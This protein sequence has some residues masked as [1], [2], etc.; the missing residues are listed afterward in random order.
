MK[1]LL[2]TLFVLLSFTAC[3][4]KEEQA[5]QEEARKIELAEFEAQKKA[6]KKAEEAQKV[7]EAEKAK[8]IEEAKLAKKALEDKIA[9]EQ[10]AKIKAQKE[11]EE[12]QKLNALGVE[13]SDG[14][15][16]ID[17]EKTKVFVDAMKRKVDDKIK[18]IS[19]DLEKG[20]IQSKEAGIDI[21]EKHIHIDLNKTQDVLKDWGQKIQVFVQE[22]DNIT[23]DKEK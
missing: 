22:F 15:F 16:S 18:S 11:A 3:N 4:E 23:T 6:L 14:K 7:L 20:I 21:N 10:E 12:K 19:D 8:L 1:H 2:V 5:K 9:E 13:M 17:T